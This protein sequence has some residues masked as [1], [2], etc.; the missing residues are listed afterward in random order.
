MNKHHVVIMAGGIGS[1]FWPYS[2]TKKPK[3]FLDVLGTGRSL[4]QMTYDRFSNIC[5]EENIHVITNKDYYQLVSEQLPT[6]SKEQILLEPIGRNTAVA[7]AYTAFKLRQKDP[8]AVMIV[9]PSDH[10]VFKENIFKDNIITAT[11][12]AKGTEKLITLG[13][14]PTR[15][16]TGYGYIQYHPNPLKKVRKVKTFTEKPEP[17]LAQ[18][19]I[20]S[21]DFV[22]NAGIFIWS[23]NSITKAFHTYLK[24]IAVIFEEGKDLYYTDKEQS[25]IDRAYTQCKSISIDYGI[26]EKATDVYMV[27]GKFGW[28]DLGSWDALHEIREKDKDNNVIDGKTLLYNTKNC[29]IKGTDDTLIVAQDLN[30]YLVTQSDNV[31]LICKKDAEKKFREFL[32]DAKTK[33]E[34]FA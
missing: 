13:I 21:G 34:A 9:T 33:G 3:Q 24:D 28:S 11:K 12:A 30:G 2:R 31:V 19:F 14:I 29:Y 5:P 10:V 8:E 20:E 4:I 18:K 16:E 32:N 22:W 6:L 7:I 1:R 15:P 17:E 23:V 27:K 26:M 25:F